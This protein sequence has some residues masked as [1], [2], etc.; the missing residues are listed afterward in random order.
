MADAWLYVWTPILIVSPVVLLDWWG[1]R[2]ERQSTH[3]RR[4]RDPFSLM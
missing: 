3:C 2:K 4:A 1:R